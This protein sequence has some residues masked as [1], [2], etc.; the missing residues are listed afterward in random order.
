MVFLG[1]NQFVCTNHLCFNKK[2]M[3]WWEKAWHIGMFLWVLFPEAVAGEYWREAKSTLPTFFFFPF[4]FSPL[5][6]PAETKYVTSVMQIIFKQ[7]QGL[8]WY[9]GEPGSLYVATEQFVSGTRPA[10]IHIISI[11]VNHWVCF[12]TLN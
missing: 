3:W 10:V 12:I 7:L 9:F 5:L 6:A 1:W 11:W 8:N 2:V 4:S